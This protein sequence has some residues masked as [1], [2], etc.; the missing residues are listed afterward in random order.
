MLITGITYIKL[1]Y[2][3]LRQFKYESRKTR[4]EENCITRNYKRHV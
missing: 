2:T 3:N 1:R 4:F